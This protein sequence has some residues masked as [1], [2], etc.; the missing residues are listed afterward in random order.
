MPDAPPVIDI[1]FEELPE[2]ITSFARLV[3]D[4]TG[5]FAILNEDAIVEVVKQL[6]K[7]GHVEKI[8]ASSQSSGCN[9][10][11]RVFAASHDQQG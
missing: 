7:L 4:Q 8:N 2:K 5:R 11:S 6:V 10:Q 9:V 1:N 3:A